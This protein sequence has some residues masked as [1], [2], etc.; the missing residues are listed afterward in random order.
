MNQPAPDPRNSRENQIFFKE[1]IPKI[2]ITT[3][4]LSGQAWRWSRDPHRAVSSHS[5][6]ITSGPSTPG[7]LQDCLR[8]FSSVLAQSALVQKSFNLHKNC[9]ECATAKEIN[10]IVFISFYP[11]FFFRAM[12]CF[13]YSKR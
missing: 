12:I 9:P 1:N 10:G 8:S 3:Q 7:I 13:Q 2:P 5:A 4:K 6:S 11:F